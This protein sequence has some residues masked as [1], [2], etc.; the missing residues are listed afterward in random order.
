MI[1]NSDVAQIHRQSRAQDGGG[2]AILVLTMV[3]TAASVGAVFAWLENVL[4]PESLCP[5]VSI[6][7]SWALIHAKTTRSLNI[8]L[9]LSGV[10]QSARRRRSPT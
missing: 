9:R 3:S 5:L 7:L 8:G 1:A 4:G 2:F 6:M 10:F